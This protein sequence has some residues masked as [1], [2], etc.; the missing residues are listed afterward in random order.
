MPSITSLQASSTKETGLTDKDTAK[1]SRPGPMEALTKELSNPTNATEKANIS[2]LTKPVM[3]ENS[4]M[5]P[6]VDSAL[7][8]EKMDA[9]MKANGLI[10]INKVTALRPGSMDPNMKVCPFNV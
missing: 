9:D 1:A 2:R 10:T 3:K 8:L 4:R 6:P 5:M 7:P